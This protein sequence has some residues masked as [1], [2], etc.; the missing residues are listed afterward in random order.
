M[1]VIFCLA[2]GKFAADRMKLHTFIIYCVLMVL[3]PA[4]AYAFL[5][6]VKAIL[7]G[8]LALGFGL[9]GFYS[10]VQF[11]IARYKGSG[12]FIAFRIPV[13]IL[14]I[15]IGISLYAD[16]PATWV[17]RVAAFLVGFTLSFFISREGVFSALAAKQRLERK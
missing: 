8:A 9:L 14:G 12:Y 6:D 4:L 7:S 13:L 10:M 17:A 15:D 2:A 1:G 16:L 3:I 11:M 5:V